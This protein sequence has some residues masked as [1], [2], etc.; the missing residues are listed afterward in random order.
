MTN[1][2]KPFPRRVQLALIKAAEGGGSFSEQLGRAE[3]NLRTPEQSAEFLVAIK[4]YE[5]KQQP[6]PKSGQ[7]RHLKSKIAKRNAFTDLMAMSFVEGWS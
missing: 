7:A 3:A 4:A 5:A 1:P 2:M 6:V